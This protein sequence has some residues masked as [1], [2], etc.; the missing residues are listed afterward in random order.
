MNNKPSIL[1][2]VW[3]CARYDRI[4]THNHPYSL[5]PNLDSFI[6]G[7]LDY[8][9]AYSAATWSLPS[10]TS[11]LTGLY[12]RQH[13][14]NDRDYYLPSHIPTIAHTLQ[15]VG[16]KTACFSNN[17]WLEPTF[18][19][20]DRFQ[21]FESMWFSAQKDVP[22]KLAF[23]N[24][25]VYGVLA[26]K[27]DKGARR[28]NG[29]IIKWI[30]E[31]AKHPTFTFAAYMEPH[32]PYTSFWKGLQRFT[33][34]AWGRQEV[35]SIQ[36]IESLP[37][38]HNFARGELEAINQQYNLEMTYIDGMF[39]HLIR[40]LTQEK[41]LDNTIVIVTADHGELLGEHQ[42]LG[43]QFSVHEPLRHVP[44]IIWA[45]SFWATSRTI[46]DLVQTID[47]PKTIAN[48]CNVDW[49]ANSDYTYLLPD[50]DSEGG[51]QFAITDYPEPYLRLVKKKYPNADLQKI[52]VGL[53]CISNSRHKV[54]YC[55]DNTWHGYDLLLDPQEEQPQTVEACDQLSD[56]RKHLETYLKQISPTAEVQGEIPKAVIDHLRAL[57]YIE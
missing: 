32:M 27:I 14:V 19:A 9:N 42:M 39:G 37:A 10:Y 25:K 31:N 5:T 57:G 24:D 17:A 36:W 55:S 53:S 49:E 48:W 2:I 13:G 1:W 23:I 54:T 50:I 20:G 38:V 16:Y 56:L 11:L 45:P 40:Q 8:R 29:K 34:K 52:N 28:T 6:K 30:R 12:P 44:L 26:G 46:H 3:D 41:L 51:R 47:L 43:H 22:S 15:E 18:G 4:S 33:S 7:R 21:H 35:K